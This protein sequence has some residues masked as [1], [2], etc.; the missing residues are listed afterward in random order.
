[1][2]I[3]ALPRERAK[4]LPDLD[5]WEQSARIDFWVPDLVRHPCPLGERLEFFFSFGS[6]LFFSKEK[7]KRML[8]AEWP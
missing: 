1:M 2:E 5:G 8:A 4:I 7:K 6:F 3:F